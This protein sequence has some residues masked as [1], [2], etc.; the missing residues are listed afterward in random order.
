MD[1]WLFGL[2]VLVCTACVQGAIRGHAIM[3]VLGTQPGSSAKA[4]KC[5]TH[6]SHLCSPKW[7]H[8]ES[9]KQ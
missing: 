7:R 8:F 4:N 1:L 5:G 6:L 9:Y 2:H 3:Q